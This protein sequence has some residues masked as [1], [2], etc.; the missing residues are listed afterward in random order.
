[1]KYIYT[2]LLLFITTC[3]L[4]QNWEPFPYDS[5]Y[6][7]NPNGGDILVPFVK[8]NDSS[9]FLNPM[10]TSEE[11]Q[12]IR[13]L[14]ATYNGNES[15]DMHWFG[16]N[17]RDSSGYLL[18][19]SLYFNETIKL[20]LLGNLYETD[21][22]IFHTQDSIPYY[23]KTKVDSIYYD[24]DLNDSIKSINITLLNALF[25]EEEIDYDIFDFPP[26]GYGV[27]ACFVSLL[28][29][30]AS[31][32][33]KHI[34]IGKNSGIIEI[35]NLTFY[36]Y[37]KSYEKYI[38]V[39]SLKQFL[40]TPML[41]IGDR[42]EEVSKS[43]S[44]YN[45]YMYQYEYATEITA[46]QNL[47][48]DSIF[49][50]SAKR[51]KKRVP[52]NGYQNNMTPEYTYDSEFVINISYSYNSYFFNGLDKNKNS[53]SYF[54]KMNSIW[55]L[56]FLE[57]V[58]GQ[59]IP[60]SYENNNELCHLV[61][62]TDMYS[63]QA[64]LSGLYSES[65]LSYYNINGQEN[66]TSNHLN[67]KEQEKLNDIIYDPVSKHIYIKSLDMS[68]KSEYEIVNMLGQIITL[69][70]LEMSIDVSHID[71]SGVY[72]LKTQLSNNKINSFKFIIE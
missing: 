60:L 41:N 57:R 1:M 49:S 18:F 34:R 38:T 3:S 26:Y 36:P 24:N 33:N 21:T 5:I 11:D 68:N 61:N 32:N 15:P 22:F 72:L 10:S 70:K 50:Y 4:S 14:L 19:S 12:L 64:A 40:S 13:E 8:S 54:L 66:G 67:V 35:P 53:E 17:L 16:E 37:C 6:F 27:G 55:G 20:N 25:E 58:N 63:S 29:V 7:I 45:D 71:R 47:S 30:E 28:Y 39:D 69:G 2:L 59:Y 46:F 52:Y 23:L 51:W 9:Q 48:Q 42:Y 44:L 62:I 31:T 65:C 56:P 43:L